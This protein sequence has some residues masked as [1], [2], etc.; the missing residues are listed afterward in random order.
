MESIDWQKHHRFMPKEGLC[1]PTTIWMI[2]SACGIR[3]PLWLISAYT[4][5]KWWG[6]PSQL[7]I[8]YLSRYFS[9]VNFKT[10]AR[11]SDIAF[12]I[13]AGHIVVINWWDNGEGHYSIVSDY[14]TGWI[15]IVD[16][17]RERDWKYLMS[18]KELRKKWF[19]TLDINDS[20]YHT[21]LMIWIDPK[22]KR[23]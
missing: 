9:L 8:G 22:S 5:K 12:H 21:E 23:M 4:Y 1:G 19:D 16:S 18:T 13:K 15:T 2:L 3:K 7:F 6:C 10:N 11:I 20:L 14:E 17:S